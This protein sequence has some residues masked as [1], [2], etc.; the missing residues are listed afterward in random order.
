MGV[1]QNQTGGEICTIRIAHDNQTSFAEIVSPGGSI[2]KLCQL[3]R[4]G[5][6]VFN[7]NLGEPS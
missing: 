6:D 1:K 7:A 2:D 4:P 3:F 5:L